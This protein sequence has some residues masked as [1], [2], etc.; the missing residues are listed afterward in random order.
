MMRSITKGQLKIIYHAP[1]K[2]IPGIFLTDMESLVVAWIKAPSSAKIA[3]TSVSLT[4][5][6]SYAITSS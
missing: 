1:L 2:S 6:K 5:T 3:C 4:I